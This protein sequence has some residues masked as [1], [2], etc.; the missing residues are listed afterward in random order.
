MQFEEL[1]GIGQ[2]DLAFPCEPDSLAGAVEEPAADLGLQ[3][4]DLLAHGRLGQEELPGRLR[5]ASH[6]RHLVKCLELVDIH[7]NP[8]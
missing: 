5:E 8:L 2:Q 1:L 4:A 6:G 7:K 3:G